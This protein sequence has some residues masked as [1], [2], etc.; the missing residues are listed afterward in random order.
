MLSWKTRLLLGAATLGLATWIGYRAERHIT[1]AAG[2]NPLTFRSVVR[3]VM[4]PKSQTE[5]I[6][7]LNQ[8]RHGAG[9]SELGDRE[10]AECWSI[11]RGFTLEDVQAG[12]AEIPAKP[13]YQANQALIG[14]LF[15][16]WAQLD[17]E[18]A[19]QAALKPEHEQNY[20]I[21]MAVGAAWA[22]KDPEAALRWSATSD[23]R[24]A[25]NVFGR[26]AGRMLAAQDPEHALA[27]VTTEFPQGLFGVVEA[28]VQRSETPESRL[29]LFSKLKA[30]PD[31]KALDYCLTLLT[32]RIYYQNP[33]TLRSMLAD[34]E[35]A[36]LPP[37][38]LARIKQT[39]ESSLKF[40][41]PEES[42][43]AILKPGS[44]STESEQKNAY[45]SW[46]NSK[47]EE[48]SAWAV[49]NGRTDLVADIVKNQVMSRLRAG[50][51]MGKRDLGSTIMSDT[52]TPQFEAWQKQDPQAVAAWLQ[53]MPL[54]VRNYYSKDHAAH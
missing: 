34:V 20:F 21:L 6:K 5:L 24:F 9:R 42:F 19:V 45:N 1:D 49:A 27:K 25:K 28:L 32:N 51:Q 33:E 30:L 52:L 31:P 7:R 16:R 14:M 8:L 11:I 18:A 29:E 35:A 37:E 4:A 2:N 15:F 47:P 40:E 26:A 50:W 12:L 53:T 17:P 13:P 39:I 46:A 48:A 36:D 41:A 43:G 44:A 10:I 54:D 3:R 38:K 23:S 22:A